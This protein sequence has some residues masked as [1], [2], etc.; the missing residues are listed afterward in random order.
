MWSTPEWDG[1]YQTAHLLILITL[2]VLTVTGISYL[3]EY[4]NITLF[5][6]T[7]SP[8]ADSAMAHYTIAGRILLNIKHSCLYVDM[9]SITADVVLS[10]RPSF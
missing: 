8:K 5:C 3:L 10:T 7:P 1:T 6:R 4:H 2:H 9:T